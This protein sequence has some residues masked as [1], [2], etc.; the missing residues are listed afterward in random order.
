PRPGLLAGV[1]AWAG[2]PPH[3]AAAAGRAGMRL[4]SNF[5]LHFPPLR[6]ELERMLGRRGLTDLMR[7]ADLGP[8]VE[9]R[10]GWVRVALCRE[11][12]C[13]TEFLVLFVQ[14]DAGEMV[15]C[16]HEERWVPHQLR[17]GD[18]RGGVWRTGAAGRQ[19][20]PPEGCNNRGA[21]HGH[22]WDLLRRLADG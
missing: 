18:N 21:L 20:L 1:T 9:R 8:P 17:W 12:H 11:G 2:C 7:L 14:P 5:V 13:A 10:D 15:L 4:R 16:W 6:S 22:D 19:P 3:C